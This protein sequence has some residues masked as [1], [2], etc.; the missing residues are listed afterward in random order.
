MKVLS[1][2]VGKPVEINWRGKKS[3]SG[4]Y[5]YPTKVKIF[6]SST[7]LE[8]DGQGNLKVH[9]GIDKAIY[10]YPH[11][12]Y[13]YWKEQF[14]EME[15]PTG[16][17]GENLTTEGLDEFETCIGD[18][19]KIGEIIVEISEPRFPCVTLAARFGTPVIVKQFLNSYKSGF[20]LRVLKEGFV[21]SGDSISI[22]EKSGDRFSV[23]DFVR[24]YI[25]KDNSELKEKALANKAISE[26]WKEKIR[27]Y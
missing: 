4:I 18:K 11:E 8:G 13:R 23:A 22:H 24:L 20:Y 2:N 27:C 5:K 19:L 21:Q 3:K 16:M 12:H 25:N 9:G 15:F 10:V 6:A 17:F 26:R 1:V 14:T 7:N